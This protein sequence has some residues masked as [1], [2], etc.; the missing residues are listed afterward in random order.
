[1]GLAAYRTI[2]VKLSGRPT[3]AIRCLSHFQVPTFPALAPSKNGDRHD[4][5]PFSRSVRPGSASSQS[6]FSTRDAALLNVT[7]R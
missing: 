5:L 7:R 6:P 3:A 4:A 2:V 1:M